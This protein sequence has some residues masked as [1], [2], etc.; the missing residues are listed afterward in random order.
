MVWSNELILLAPRVLPNRK[1][2]EH[3]S[4]IG[5]YTA[6]NR[7]YSKGFIYL[8]FKY[9]DAK[10]VKD[11]EGSLNNTKYYYSMKLLYVNSKYFIIFT[12]YIDDINIEE[13]KEHG[14]IGFTIED[15]ALIFIFWGDLVKD[16]PQF[17]N[18][19]IFECKNKLNEKDLL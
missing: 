5:L 16:M 2:L 9:I 12:F 3:S 8:V 13:Y 1:P 7:E 14:N 17:Y 15:Y 18:E 4:F 11:L 6:I 10:Q 19:D